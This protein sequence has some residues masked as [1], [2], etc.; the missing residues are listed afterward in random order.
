MINDALKLSVIDFIDSLIPYL[1][2]TI[3]LT[4]LQ[5]L[6]EK[7]IYK[8]ISSNDYNQDIQFLKELYKLT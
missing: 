3:Y 7:Y 5:K 2:T 6:R 4:D 1:E 8:D